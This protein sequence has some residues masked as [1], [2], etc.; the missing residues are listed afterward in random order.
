MKVSQETSESPG[1]GRG[2]VTLAG[3]QFDPIIEEE[4]VNRVL[5]ALSEGRGG[6]II[7]PNVDILHRA[8]QDAEARHHI[9]ASEITVADGKPLIW[10]SRLAGNSLPARV[11]GSDLIW[12][13]SEAMSTAGRSVYLLGGEPGTAERAE[14]V[15]RERFPSLKLAGHLSPSFGFDTREDEYAAVCDEVVAA[16]P[17]MVFV[18]FGFPKQERVIERL[19]PRLPQSWFMGCG[20]AIGF[21]AGVHSR[22]PEWMQESGLEW[23]HRLASEPRR[24]VRRYLIDDAPF[25]VRLLAASARDRMGR[26]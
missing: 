6:Q 17:D 26:K 2:S 10:A 4:V 21:V 8:A 15:L 12:S 13:L 24:L 25:A 19:R 11:P 16:A 3:V 7:T 20:A 5:T 9:E 14:E 18:G 23:V 1:H 22:A